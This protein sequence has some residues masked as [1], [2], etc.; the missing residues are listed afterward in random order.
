MTQQPSQKRG[1]GCLGYGC[2][3]AVVLIGLTIGG[4]FWLARS[5]MRNAVQTFTT[6]R[7]VA[8]PTVPSDE[9]ARVSLATKVAEIKRVMSEPRSSGEFL[10]S[11]S[12]LQ[13]AL[14]HTP[15]NGK[16]FV[17]LQGDSVAATFSFPLKALGDW[18]AA[19]PIIGDYLNRY[20]TGSARAAVS[21][22]A[23]VASITF[24]ELVLNG[25][26]FDGDALKEASEWVSGFLNSQVGALEEK[27]RD[28]IESVKLADGVAVLRVKP[29]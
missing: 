2:I 8:V 7:A 5:A 18:E 17:E 3:V 1:F 29:E 9:A 27:R 28:R 4:I 19:K 6:E 26:V 16:V 11:Q 15:F 23:G 10:L 25:Q 21:V 13:G 12:E 20:V 24:S 14:A 22:S